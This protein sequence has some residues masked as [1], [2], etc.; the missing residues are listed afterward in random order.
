MELDT[1]VTQLR[2]DF[3]NTWAV[4]D[5]AHREEHF[6]AVYRCGLDIQDKLGM[7]FDPKLILLVAY[8]HDLFAWSRV[9]HHQ[10]S[11]NWV[12]T[13]DYPIIAELTLEDRFLVADGCFEHRAS[14]TDQF[15]NMFAE[16][17][18]SADRGIP[19]VDPSH[20]F[21]RSF[22]CN[23]GKTRDVESSVVKAHAHVIEKFGI[24]G[25]ARFSDVYKAAYGEV[26][27]QQQENVMCYTIDEM[28]E[29][30]KLYL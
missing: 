27:K 1:I 23:Y 6:N 13:T 17:M 12:K 14:N 4:N 3:S 5:P 25:Y 24:G 16:L 2:E 7:S 21:Q 19:N 10:L 15:S 29:S 22:I 18:N 26:L 8:F 30:V 9:N 11:H 28:R 20:L